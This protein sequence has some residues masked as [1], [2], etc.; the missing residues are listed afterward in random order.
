MSIPT[1]PDFSLT[2]FKPGYATDQ[3]DAFLATIADR[4]AQEINDV[5]FR[6]T[7]FFPGYDEEEVDAYLDA[8]IAHKR[9]TSTAS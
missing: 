4:T 6:T 1:R 3:V 7:R 5:E 8:C 9:S 2:R